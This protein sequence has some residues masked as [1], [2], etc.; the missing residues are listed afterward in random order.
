M[1]RIFVCTFFSVLCHTL[2]IH[3]RVSE[4]IHDQSAYED[5]QIQKLVSTVK[6]MPEEKTYAKGQTPNSY[7]TLEVVPPSQEKIENIKH[8]CKRRKQL[9]TLVRTGTLLGGVGFIAWKLLHKKKPAQN[10]SE[11]DLHQITQR[12]S[13]LEQQISQAATPPFQ[14]SRHWLLQE[15]QQIGTHTGSLILDGLIGALV[16]DAITGSITNTVT[17]QIPLRELLARKPSLEWFLQSHTNYQINCNSFSHVLKELAFTQDQ[18]LIRYYLWYHAQEFM[19]DLEQILGFLEFEL[20]QPHTKQQKNRIQLHM[21][22]IKRT[23]HSLCEKLNSFLGRTE[24]TTQLTTPIQENLSYI[25][26][27]IEE[28]RATNT[29]SNMFFTPI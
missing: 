14:S 9:F 20:T 25:Q 26:N 15:A 5:Y 1:N 11:E 7:D 28:V 22:T 3:A 27:T 12:I 10:I 16:V 13:T 8:R 24:I 19:H 17:R 18:D 29:R 23:S 2:C 4:P 21:Q 6:D